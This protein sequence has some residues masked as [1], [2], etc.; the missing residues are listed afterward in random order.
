MYIFHSSNMLWTVNGAGV[1]EL[2]CVVYELL[3]IIVFIF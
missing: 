3:I 1:E 2:K